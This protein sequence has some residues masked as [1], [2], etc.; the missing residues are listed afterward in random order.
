[1][2]YGG[3]MIAIFVAIPFDQAV[4]K[5]GPLASKNSAFRPFVRRT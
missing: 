1:L 5:S 4:G 2:Q 3:E